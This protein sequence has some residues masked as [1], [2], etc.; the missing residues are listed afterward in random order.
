MH[1]LLLDIQCVG[2]VKGY[3]PQGILDGGLGTSRQEVLHCPKTVSLCGFVKG[4]AE[5]T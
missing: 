3:L 4:R 2:A 5:G 1:S